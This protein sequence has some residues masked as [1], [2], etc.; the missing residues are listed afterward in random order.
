MAAKKV[1]VTWSDES[2]EPTVVKITPRAQVA[3]ERHI[4][5]DWSG[6]ALLSVYYMAWVALVKEDPA[7]TPGFE[8]WLD[9]VDDVEEVAEPKPDP[10]QPA[11][12]DETSLN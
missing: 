2:R 1:K 4:G 5:G 10:T 7:A 11:Q 3:T 8:A 9:S 12:S 6:M